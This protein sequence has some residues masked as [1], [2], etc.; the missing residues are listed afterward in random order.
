MAK[1]WR[2]KEWLITTKGVPLCIEKGHPM[3]D[4]YI[5]CDEKFQVF[6]FAFN[7]Y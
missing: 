1:F 2:L 7:H 5:L 4:L 3:L 6:L